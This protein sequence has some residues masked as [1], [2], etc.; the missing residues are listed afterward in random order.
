[1]ADIKTIF[2]AIDHLNTYQRVSGTHLLDLY[3]QRPAAR[4]TTGTPV[5]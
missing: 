2:G 5:G 1:M 4:G 3:I